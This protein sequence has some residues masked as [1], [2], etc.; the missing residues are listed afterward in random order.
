[1]KEYENIKALKTAIEKGEVKEDDLQIILDN[2]NVSFYCWDEEFD[3]DNFIDI[4]VD[5]AGG[6]RDIEELYKL[7]FPK[8]KVNWC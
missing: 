3:P 5:G 7:V 1:M 6:Y 8:A 2:D 4:E